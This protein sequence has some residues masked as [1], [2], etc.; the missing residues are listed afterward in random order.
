MLT[1]WSVS[2]EYGFVFFRGN[3]EDGV[4]LARS[5]DGYHWAERSGETILKGIVGGGLTRDPS[6]LYG[7]DGLYHMVWT[8]DWN[9]NGFGLAHSHDLQTWSRQE[10]VP[11]MDTIPDVA[12]VWAPEIFFDKA[13]CRYVVI[14]ASTVG[15]PAREG[16]RDHR[17]WCAT[18][19]DF[20]SWS[21]PK[22]FFNPGFNVI[23]AFPL[24]LKDCPL[25]VVKDERLGRKCLFVAHLSGSSVLSPCERID[26]PF[27]RTEDGW[28]E[29]PTALALADGTW[30]VYFDEYRK[31]QYGAVTT[32]DFMTFTRCHDIVLPKGI[33]HGTTFSI[34]SQSGANRE[35]LLK[36]PQ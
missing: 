12:N 21:E 29:G 16:K 26:E 9:T 15:E 25:F 11:V 20:K 8:T 33:R 27:T 22:E 7:Q 18:T 28:A 1:I 31:R 32:R 10:F 30:V 35:Q 36:Q 6:V 3:G 34:A 19:K 17:Q 13:T 14:W 23:D 2:A 24:L 4:Y 5:Q